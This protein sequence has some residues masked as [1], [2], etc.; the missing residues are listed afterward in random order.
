MVGCVSEEAG[1]TDAQAVWWTQQRCLGFNQ[2]E[3]PSGGL[4]AICNALLA[5]EWLCI[6]IV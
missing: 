2:I 6:C 4:Q 1:V 5:A 3:K